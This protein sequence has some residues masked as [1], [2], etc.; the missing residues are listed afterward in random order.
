MKDEKEFFNGIKVLMS[1]S[2]IRVKIE[3]GKK[4]IFLHPLVHYL[5]RAR[6]NVENQW[7]WK[8]RV[9][10]WLVQ[11]SAAVEAD[12]VYFPHVREQMQQM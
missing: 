7:R 5:S 11:A 12:M 2:L 6:L 9:I 3:A 4:S 1:F 8:L 10:S